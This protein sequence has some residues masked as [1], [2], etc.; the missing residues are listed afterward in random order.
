M[1]K[2]ATNPQNLRPDLRPMGRP[3]GAK[4]KISGSIKDQVIECW[5]K[6]QKNPKLSLYGMAKNNPE[7]FY[8]TFG[9]ALIPR[10]IDVDA[11]VGGDLTIQVVKFVDENNKNSE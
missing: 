3:K 11:T 8:A 2:K 9:R 5:D 1:P 7:W 4:N 10:Q 6:L